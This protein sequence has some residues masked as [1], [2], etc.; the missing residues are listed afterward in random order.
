[1]TTTTR[2]T[3]RHTIV[4]G[5]V[6]ECGGTG[7]VVAGALRAEPLVVDVEGSE[8]APIAPMTPSIAPAL[9]PVTATRAPAAL[10]RRR[11]PASP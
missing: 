8:C 9:N 5:V 11:R 2:C 4:V 6:A 10:W 7:R 1:V 3:T